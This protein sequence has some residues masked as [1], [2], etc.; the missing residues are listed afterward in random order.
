MA[1]EHKQR[2]RIVRSGQ[3]V[4]RQRV[5]EYTPTTR[6]IVV[7]RISQLLWLVAAIIIS[8][9]AVRFALKLIAANPANGFVSFI[10][11]V[12]DVLVA[13][14]NGITTA[15]TAGTAQIDVA[16]LIAVVVYLLVT[17]VIVTL[18]RIIFADTNGVRHVSTVERHVDE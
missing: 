11:S 8:L 13:P 15:P 10:M 3:S 9:I 7:S 12:T 2:T 16:A 14:F 6:S 18:F 5:V 17:W 1:T 4:Q